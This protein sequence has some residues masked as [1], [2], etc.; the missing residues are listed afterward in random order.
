MDQLL[1]QRVHQ[2]LGISVANGILSP[3]ITTSIYSDT[4]TTNVNAGTGAGGTTSSSI[5]IHAP[6]ASTANAN[7]GK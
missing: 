3:I 6:T 1:L 7:S 4:I 2:R 5:L